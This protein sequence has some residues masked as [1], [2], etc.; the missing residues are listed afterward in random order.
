[1]ARVTPELV[2]VPASPDLMVPVSPQPGSYGL[3]ASLA[4]LR[5]TAEKVPIRYV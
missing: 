4:L 3:Q 5:H 2:V 1:M